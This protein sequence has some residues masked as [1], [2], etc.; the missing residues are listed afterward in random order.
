MA[1]RRKSVNKTLRSPR[2][3]V[4]VALLERQ[5]ALINDV[6]SSLSDRRGDIPATSRPRKLSPPTKYVPYLTLKEAEYRLGFNRWRIRRLIQQGFLAKCPRP[7]TLRYGITV[8][9]VEKFEAQVE[10]LNDAERRRPVKLSRYERDL[11]SHRDN[12]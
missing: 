4:D 11:L 8:K 6:R 9:S 1:V 2:V 10:C 5:R 7:D 12:D 3:R